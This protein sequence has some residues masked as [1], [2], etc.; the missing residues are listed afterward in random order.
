[1]DELENS[2]HPLLTEKLVR[3]FLD[4]LNADDR[5]QLVFTTHELRLMQIPLLRRD[6]MWL[7]D[8]LN[9]QTRLA[10]MSE[11]SRKGVRKDADILGLYTSGRLGGVP[12]I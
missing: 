3:A 11:Y 8:K 1:M 9:G 6:E 10:R 2:M 4:G 5:R 12:R 7:A